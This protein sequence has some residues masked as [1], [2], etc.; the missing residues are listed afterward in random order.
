M[1]MHEAA[2]TSWDLP[3]LR[4][5]RQSCGRLALEALQ[6]TLSPTLAG[7][8]AFMTSE[9]SQVLHE[10]DICPRAESVPA[11]WAPLYLKPKVDIF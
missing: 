10:P 5:A 8:L 1:D 2:G 3:E 11:F 7:A 6:Q 9:S 4:E